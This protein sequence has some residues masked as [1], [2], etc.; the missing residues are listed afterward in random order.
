MID[1]GATTI[2]ERWEGFDQD[3]MPFESHN[4]YSK[5]AV[6]SYFHR[7]IAG[8]R[9]L[10]EHP[11]YRHFEVRPQ[12]GGGLTWARASLES[13]HGLIEVEWRLEA[14]EFTLEVT[15]P[16]GTMCDIVLPDRRRHPA[17]SSG[18][19]QFATGVRASRSAT[20]RANGSWPRAVEGGPSV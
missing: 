6:I 2:W 18:T 8:I 11:G 5:G 4:H 9:L 10:T 14:D 13:P 17:I 3:G 12:P 1:R 20:E 19:H 7:Y 16:P 15:V